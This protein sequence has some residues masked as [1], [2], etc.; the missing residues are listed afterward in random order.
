MAE[1]VPVK[2]LSSLLF[3]LKN[4]LCKQNTSAQTR[5]R[6]SHLVSDGAS[7]ISD[8]GEVAETEGPLE[9]DRPDGVFLRR[10]PSGGH[11]RRRRHNR[12]SRHRHQRGN[13]SPYLVTDINKGLFV[14]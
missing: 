4:I 13:R 10:L 1:C 12:R 11:H 14:L 5:E 9:A 3:F 6:C 7:L 8:G 2:S